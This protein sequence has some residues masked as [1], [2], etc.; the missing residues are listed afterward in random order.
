MPDRIV[1]GL[2]KKN[3]IVTPAE[4]RAIAVHE[5]GHATASWMLNMPRLN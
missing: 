5:A 1:G 4:K 3:K 2:E